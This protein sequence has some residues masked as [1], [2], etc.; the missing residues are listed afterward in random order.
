MNLKKLTTL[1]K[2]KG[3]K[4]GIIDQSCHSGNSMAL[5]DDNTCVLSVTGP[6]HYGYA[7]PGTDSAKLTENMTPGKNLEDLFLEARRTSGDS[8]FPMISS[9]AGKAVQEQLY[10]MLTPYLYYFDNKSDKLTPFITGTQE[11]LVCKYDQDFEQLNQMIN[12]IE[13][14]QVVTKQFLFFKWNETTKKADLSALKQ[15]LAEYYAFQKDILKDVA[16]VDLKIFNT[17]EK[18]VVSGGNYIQSIDYTWKELVS[19]DFDKII[20]DANTRLSQATT[21]FEKDSLKLNME[22]YKKAKKR[23]EEIAIQHPEY[24]TLQTKLA[25]I[26]N[27]ESKSYT[28]ANTVGKESRALYDEL[29]KKVKNSETTATQPNP[30][31]EF[32]L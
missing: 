9:P 11:D 22:L 16:G 6:N 3:V 28:L 5:A 12:N 29:Y 30:C 31:K 25:S 21:D 27:K 1:A 26:E 18:I 32:I 14:I 4:V 2:E 13:D 7:G 23:G 10:G 15:A 8:G 19:I 20:A 17:S 24:K